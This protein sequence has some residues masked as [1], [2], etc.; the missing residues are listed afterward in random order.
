MSAIAEKIVSNVMAKRWRALNGLPAVGQLF[1][2]LYSGISTHYPKLN[3]K[4]AGLLRYGGTYR[5]AYMIE[6]G[7]VKPWE[8]RHLLD[9]VMR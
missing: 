5:G 7:V 2:A 1:C 9:S 3:P 8:L 4:Y 6:R